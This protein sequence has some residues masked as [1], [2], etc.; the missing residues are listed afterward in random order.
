[1]QGLTRDI[2]IYNVDIRRV[3]VIETFLEDKPVYYKANT[4]MLIKVGKNIEYL[5]VGD[6]IVW[7]K[8][9]DYKVYSKNEWN[10]FY[11]AKLKEAAKKLWDISGIE[12]V[13]NGEMLIGAI[14]TQLKFKPL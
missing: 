13:N 2:E 10:K 1:M 4:P 11:G 14:H 5:N 6:Y 12:N 8:N 3:P 7:D 9:G